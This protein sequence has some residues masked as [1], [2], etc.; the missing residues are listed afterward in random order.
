MPSGSEKGH[1]SSPVSG[2]QQ[3]KLSPGQGP[4]PGGPGPTAEHVPCR[5]S[6]QPQSQVS[7]HSTPALALVQP[8]RQKQ[9][10]LCDKFRSH[11]CALQAGWSWVGPSAL[12]EPQCPHSYSG[13]ERSTCLSSCQA[14]HLEQ[15]PA[16][17]ELCPH[18]CTSSPG[19]LRT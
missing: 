2:G 3:Q 1:T 14:E 11:L 10:S 4:E 12:S 18:L 19:L 17:I 6:P 8:C 16:C 7:T 5:H 15:C 9:G 13:D